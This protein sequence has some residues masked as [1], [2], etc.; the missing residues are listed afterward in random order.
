MS[1]PPG[2]TMDEPCPSCGS[3]D[4]TE[5]ARKYA[6]LVPVLA[7]LV[8]WPDTPLPDHVK[9]RILDQLGRAGERFAA[10]TTSDEGR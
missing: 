3:W 2:W 6:P 9:A 1:H 4:I 10:V 5:L 8:A 7:D